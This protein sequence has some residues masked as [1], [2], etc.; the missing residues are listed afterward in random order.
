[1]ARCLSCALCVCLWL[2]LSAVHARVRAQTAPS[3]DPAPTDAP[4][5]RA[6]DPPPATLR[7]NE[8]AA[9]P[10]RATGSVDSPVLRARS[11]DNPALDAE[12]ARLRST[13]LSAVPQAGRVSRAQANASWVLGLLYLHGIGVA[14]S[15]D[16]AATWFERAQ[17]LGEPLAPAGL[18]W[19][20]IEGCKGTPNPAAA[21]RWIT[22]L[23]AANLPR[24]Q[25]LQWLME[26]R[27]S[28]LQIATPGLRSE[29][30][31]AG[32][33][34]RQLLLSAAQGGDIH[35]R[36]ELGLESVTANRPAEALEHFRAVAPR[37]P[38]AS[39]NQ[40][41]LSERLRSTSN[42]RRPPTSSSSDE[43]FA[44]AQR[45]HRGAGQPANF[46]EAIRFYRL[47][48]S[49][50]SAEARKMLE[51]I[52]S[53]PAPDG[54]IDLAWMQQLAYV[55]LSKDV[56]TLD[57]AAVRQGLRREPTPLIDLLPQT[58]R[59]YASELR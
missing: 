11:A 17:A 53:R 41:L 7:A 35:A 54:Q 49:Q 13:A 6:V 10:L 18:A 9:P 27:L 21:G 3:F 33:P 16:E 23:R 29:P 37:S 55:N 12:V 24:A 44:R 34:N 8:V 57:S 47:A 46:V 43:T 56:V 42:A 40:V 5:I 15:P 4:Q 48:Q 2:G 58:W 14:A 45:N 32:W 39:S 19:C 31:S 52:F 30:A 1:M 59:K 36:I 38:A 28:P 22:L 20:E 51:L 25:Y 50:G 26:A